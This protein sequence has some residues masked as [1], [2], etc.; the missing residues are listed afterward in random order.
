MYHIIVSLMVNPLYWKILV[1]LILLLG[2]YKALR[3]YKTLGKHTDFNSIK[4]IKWLHHCYTFIMQII[5][6]FA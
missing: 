2:L 1:A 6:Q 3:L 4:Y 5:K